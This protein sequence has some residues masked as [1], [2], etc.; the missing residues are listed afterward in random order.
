[1][2]LRG[3]L[4]LDRYCRRQPVDLVDVRLLHHLE[5]LPRIGRERLDV[6]ALAFGVDRVEGERGFARARQ[7]GEHD[8]TVA[9]NGDVDVFQI[10]LARAADG[11]LAGVAG[12]LAVTFGHCV[13]DFVFDLVGTWFFQHSGKDTPPARQNAGP[14]GP[15]SDGRRQK[16][17][18]LPARTPDRAQNHG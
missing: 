8:E 16:A 7:A 1:R 15:L 5:E 13:R 17:D 14:F 10:V 4:L 2:I 18:P 9:R 11:D 3:R 6:T 12:K